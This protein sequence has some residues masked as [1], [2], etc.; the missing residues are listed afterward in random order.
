MPHPAA[1]LLLITSPPRWLLR[2]KV[3]TKLLFL[4]KEDKT[5]T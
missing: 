4:G 3:A 1:L 2:E 5:L